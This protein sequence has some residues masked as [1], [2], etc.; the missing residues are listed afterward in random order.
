MPEDLPSILRFEDVSVSF[1][2]VRALEGVSFEARQGESRVI[3]GSAD[4]QSMY[5]I[6]AF[7]ELKTVWHPIGL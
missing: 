5:E 3:L 6:S 4:S 1:D 2:D 7:L